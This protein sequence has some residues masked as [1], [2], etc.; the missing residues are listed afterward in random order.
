MNILPPELLLI[1][2]N[3]CPKSDHLALKTVCKRWNILISNKK[4]YQRFEQS[5]SIPSNNF[6]DVQKIEYCREN[7][8]LTTIN[9][10]TIK[11]YKNLKLIKSINI[12]MKYCILITQNEKKFIFVDLDGY[13]RTIRKKDFFCSGFATHKQILFL[14]IDDKRNNNIYIVDR[15]TWDYVLTIYTVGGKILKT[16]NLGTNLSYFILGYNQNIYY[17]KSNYK[18]ITCLKPRNKVITYEIEKNVINLKYYKSK[19]NFYIL[20]FEDDVIEY[21]KDFNSLKKIKCDF[22]VFDYILI[23]DFFVNKIG[24]IYTYGYNRSKIYLCHHNKKI[25]IQKH[26]FFDRYGKLIILDNKSFIIY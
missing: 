13:I 1:I 15:K 8:I 16:V 26:I 6:N 21:D 10:N 14:S 24:E 19:E 18:K 5:T 25:L 17:S 4:L 3:F 22:G 20:T 12:I 11:F 23:V 7:D 9:Y 2:F